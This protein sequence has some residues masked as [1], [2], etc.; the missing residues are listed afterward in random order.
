M[1]YVLQTYLWCVKEIEFTVTCETP[2]NNGV[3]SIKFESQYLINGGRWRKI[4]VRKQRYGVQKV[5]KYVCK[6]LL[7][8]MSIILFG[9]NKNIGSQTSKVLPISYLIIDSFHAIKIMVTKFWKKPTVRFSRNVSYPFWEIQIYYIMFD[10]CLKIN[11]LHVQKCII[12]VSC[13]GWHRT[14]QAWNCSLCEF[15]LCSGV[16]QPIYPIIS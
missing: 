13:P 11:C 8:N 15:R 10:V 5:L 14:S 1:H 4:H 6:T 9:P 7:G 3:I 2:R 16:V 12:R